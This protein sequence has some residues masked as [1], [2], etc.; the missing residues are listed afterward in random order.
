M[1]ISPLYI[2]LFT[3]EEVI[4]D[5]DT[6]LPLAAGVV[7]FYRDSQRLTPKVVYQIAGVSPNYSFLS[8]GTELTLGL[9]GTFVD[10][11]GDPF[12]PYAYPYDSEG[13]VDLYY[14][15]V[16]SEGAVPQFVRQAVPYVNSSDLPPSERTSTENEIS[17]PQFVEINFPSTGTTTISVTG[18]NTVTKVAP[19]WDLITSGTGTIELERLEPT[20][21]SVPTNPPFSLRI[22]ASSGLGASVTLRQRFNNTPSIF[23]GGFAS[24]SLAAAV[25]SGGSSF[26][27]MT[28]AP[29]TGTST[30]IIP[31][32]A[33]STDGAYH[34][35]ADNAAIIQ[36][37]N[38]AA[39][40]GY[41]DILITLPT[42]RSIAITSIQVVGTDSSIDIPFDEQPAAR[43][44]DHLFHYYEDAVV[45]QPKDNLLVGWTFGL[46][47]WQFTT[48]TL[49][50]LANNAYTA[51]QT[52]VIQQAYVDS[53]TA[54]NVAVGRASH[55]ANYAFQLQAV[56]ATNKSMLLQYI[57]PQTIRPYWGEKLSVRL[58]GSI[59]TTHS[60][61]LKF[62]V[63]LIY[64]AGL[65]GI[66][67]RTV[68]VSSWD[69]AADSIPAVSSDGWTYINSVNDPTYTLTGTM[70][71]FNFDSFQLPA[72][73]NANM[74]L[75]VAF[76]MMNAMD[77]TATADVINIERVSL[78]RNDFAIDANPETYDVVLK[79]CQYYFAKTFAQGIVPDATVPAGKEGALAYR[80]FGAGTAVG[81]DY[82]QFPSI[83]RVQLPVMTYYSTTIAS[84]ARWYN[85]TL[86]SASGLP[87]ADLIND[88]G[89]FV[90]NVQPLGTSPSDLI[91][92]HA[93]AD[94][95]L[96]I[97]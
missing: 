66:I 9:S 1:S 10:L 40:T 61:A 26:V 47:P 96:G 81:G 59:T 76:I 69:A 20:S 11:S 25:L 36:Q 21:A 35:I 37:S 93:T 43:Q 15:T 55:T 23:R 45:H 5:K 72:S 56:T 49:T 24:G 90:S 77:Q 88:R 18:S 54:N 48:T 44:K 51:D 74:T 63:R 53:A 32:T 57:S 91:I 41:V 7:K 94:A 84:N 38:P 46:N 71:D 79:K 67:S 50:N 28:Y 82:W 33:I 13:E 62:K 97:F 31:S 16:E 83:M 87:S 4:L 8:V 86:A 27:T 92:I 14:V 58:R 64:K 60:T 68:P 22:Q 39:S 70:Q 52:I 12:V 6:G 73:T 42:S 80:S 85:F 30:E 78:V 3:I 89:V 34:V 19:D 2:P 65:P 95:R 75:G 29:S 17:N